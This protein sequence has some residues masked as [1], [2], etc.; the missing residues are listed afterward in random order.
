MPET[1]HLQPYCDSWNTL[2]IEQEP[3]EQETEE[4]HQ[5][6]NQVR[7]SAVPEHNTNKQTDCCSR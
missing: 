5:T 4:H 6:S 1:Y 7:Y 2:V 3:G